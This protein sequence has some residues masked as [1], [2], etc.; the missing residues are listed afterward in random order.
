[1]MN[2]CG[3][4]KNDYSDRILRDNL[5][6]WAAL[7]LAGIGLPLLLLPNLIVVIVGL[8]LVGV[9]TFFAQAAATGFVGRIAAQPAGSISPAIFSVAW[10]EVRCSGNCSTDWA[11]RPVLRASRCRS[12]RQAVL[13]WR[14]RT[15]P[16]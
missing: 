12:P 9:G 15:A 3:V 8:M 7:A 13:T 10:S 2:S 11:G 4:T 5:N 6:D 1:M 14:C 16:E